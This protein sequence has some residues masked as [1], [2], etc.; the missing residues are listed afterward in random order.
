[1]KNIAIKIYIFISNNMLVN[2]ALILFNLD[3]KLQLSAG[4][5]KAFS[6]NNKKTEQENAGF[7]HREEIEKALVKFK[8]GL[9]TFIKTNIPKNSAILDFG[10][11]PGI[12]LKMLRD[13]FKIFGIDVSENMI[14]RAQS[15]IPEG[16]FYCGNFLNQHFEEKYKMI[17]S[18]SVL[19][20]V[21][22]S[23]INNFFKK[24]HAILEDG[25]FIYIQYPHALKV[26]DLF[27]P[28]RNYIS[29][30]PGT[31]KKACE[32]YFDIISHQ[33][34]FDGRTINSY[35]KNP[36]PTPSKD[37]RNGYLL[38]AQKKK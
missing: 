3:H 5:W 10:C 6:Y 2:N 37:F 26:F 22:V 20:Y 19:E 30:S 7:S 11:G 25:G 16:K 34:F 29:Y 15:E 23:Q 18:V 21:P 4:Q 17:Y 12:Y 35:D 36:Y 9:L 8:E 32:P 1:M 14:K 27:Y 28:D 38:I 24:S 13:N 33:Q 31:I